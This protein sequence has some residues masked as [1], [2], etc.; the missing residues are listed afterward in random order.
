MIGAAYFFVLAVF[1]AQI[2]LK[3]RTSKI[4]KFVTLAGMWA[5]ILVS[6]FLASRQQ[7]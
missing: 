2:N 5:A 1:L 3:T 7:F 6:V 4:Q